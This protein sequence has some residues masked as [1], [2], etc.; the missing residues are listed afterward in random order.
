[1]RVL[2]VGSSS[3]VMLTAAAMWRKSSK[4][5]AGEDASFAGFEAA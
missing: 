1:M 4:L 2:M 3:R 5:G